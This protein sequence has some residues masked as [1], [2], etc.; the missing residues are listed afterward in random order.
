MKDV[1]KLFKNYSEEKFCRNLLPL[2]YTCVKM[3]AARS[4]ETLLHIYQIKKAQY[5]RKE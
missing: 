4:S 2:S 5:A 3:E 1:L